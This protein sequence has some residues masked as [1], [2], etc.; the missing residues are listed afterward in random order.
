MDDHQQSLRSGGGSPPTKRAKLDSNTSGKQDG[1]YSRYA[2]RPEVH[3]L[4]YN[5]ICNRKLL[6]AAFASVVR[7]LITY[8]CPYNLGTVEAISN[9]F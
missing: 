6:V 1:L 5:F 9:I 3:T 2:K 7:Y 8:S 4:P